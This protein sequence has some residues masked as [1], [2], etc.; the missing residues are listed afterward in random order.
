MGGF[1]GATKTGVTSFLCQG[2]LMKHVSKYGVNSEP[3]KL[4]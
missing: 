4:T 3:F 2:A 1:A